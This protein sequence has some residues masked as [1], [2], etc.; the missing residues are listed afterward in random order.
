MKRL[1]V[2]LVV[3]ALAL[4]GIFILNRRPAADTPPVMV[5]KTPPAA[6]VVPIAPIKIS[7]LPA[8]VAKISADTKKPFAAFENFSAWAKNFTNGSVTLIEGER[9]AWKRRAAMGELIQNDPKRALELAVPFELRQLL[10]KQITK[11]FEERIDGRGDYE[12]LAATDFNSGTTTT[13]RK[14]QLGERRFDAFV[15]GRRGR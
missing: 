7:A 4:L 11:F 13:F 1:T 14:V 3:G 8:S 6:T 2:C 5:V 12:V 15:Y 9:L 10:P